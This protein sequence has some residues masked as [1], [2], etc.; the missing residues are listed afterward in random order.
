MIE[1]NSAPTPTDINVKLVKN[2]GS[3]KEVDPIMYQSLVGSLLLLDCPC[4]C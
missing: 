2:D 4:K 1:A 3:S